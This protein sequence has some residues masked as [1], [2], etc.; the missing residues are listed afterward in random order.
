[1]KIVTIIALL[2]L[3]LAACGGN[4]GGNA[5][6]APVAATGGPASGPANS[7]NVTFH[8]GRV[9]GE[10]FA[11]VVFAGAGW[12]DP[13]FENDK[14]TGID[15]FFKGYSNSSYAGISDEYAG[16]NAQVSSL[17]TYQGY[18]SIE[19]NIP[20]V[21]G[22]NQ[23]SV[24]AAACREATSGNFELNTSAAQVIIIYTDMRRPPTNQDCGYHA[25]TGCGGE[26]VQYIFVW[27]LD[28]D[29]ACDAQDL[30]RVNGHSNGLSNI[31]NVTAHE[32]GETRTNPNGDAW[33]G[34]LASQEVADKCAYVF[35]H[36]SIKFTDGTTWKLQTQWSNLAFD[37]GSGTDD[38]AGNPGCIDGT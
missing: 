11:R 28:D 27:N 5:I 4:N 7:P 10:V 35:A 9:L 37:A 19:S 33:W 13:E 3:S 23:A 18:A 1:M 20:S 25:S 36:N 6:P 30:P 21:D 22:A 17:L 31:A 16:T 14:L 32:L 34:P 15:K 26:H 38:D 29:S 8:G 2:T 12:T 24:A